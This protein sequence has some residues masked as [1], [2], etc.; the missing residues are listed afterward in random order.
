MIIV[1]CSKES[2]QN[3]QLTKYPKNKNKN[4]VLLTVTI[5]THKEQPYCYPP[6]MNYT[7]NISKSSKLVSNK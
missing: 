6:K 1:V 4:V 5:T 2:L 7:T 3:V